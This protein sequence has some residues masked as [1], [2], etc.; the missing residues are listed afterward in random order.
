MPNLTTH[1]RKERFIAA[2]DR[3]MTVTQAA[4]HAGVDRT[5]PYKWE[6]QDPDFASLWATS[7]ATRWAQLQDVAL[8][9]AINGNVQMIKY[10]YTRLAPKHTVD[11][12]PPEIVII[13]PEGGPTLDASTPPPFLTTSPT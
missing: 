7:R 13:W 4:K 10:L 6:D 2:I 12:T 1:Q 8:E 5:L 11:S 9:I 3:G